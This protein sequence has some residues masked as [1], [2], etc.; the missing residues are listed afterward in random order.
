MIIL[1]KSRFWF[2]QGIVIMIVAGGL[3]AGQSPAGSRVASALRQTTPRL[4]L[5]DRY[6]LGECRHVLAHGDHVLFGSS[7]GLTIL[8]VHDPATPQVTGSVSLANEVRDMAV[9]GN[10]VYV[11]N[12]NTGL[13]IID[14]TDPAKPQIIGKHQTPGGTVGYPEEDD[15]AALSVSLFGQYAVV[16]LTNNGLEVIDVSSPAHPLPAGR[17][18]SYEDVYKIRVFGNLAFAASNKEPG[19]KV[20]DLSDP[21]RPRLVSETNVEFGVVSICRATDRLYVFSG[22]QLSIYNLKA[23]DHPKWI[24]SIPLTTNS[25]VHD[26][27]ISGGFA[28]AVG[29]IGL[30]VLDLQEP[31]NPKETLSRDIGLCMAVSMDARFLYLGNWNGLQVVDISN[32]PAIQVRGAYFGRR[33]FAGM[34]AEGDRLYL[35]TALHNEIRLLTLDISDPKSPRELSEVELGAAGSTTPGHIE[36][37]AGRL[38]MLM[39]REIAVFDLSDRDRPRF[40][41]TWQCRD[42]LTDLCFDDEI[43]LVTTA[44]QSLEILDIAQPDEIRAVGSFQLPGWG[45]AIGVIRDWAYLLIKDNGLIVLNIKAPAQPQVLATVPIKNNSAGALALIQES[46]SLLYVAGAD[47]LRV[48]DIDDPAKPKILGSYSSEYFYDSKGISVTGKNACVAATRGAFLFDVGDPQ[49]PSLKARFPLPGSA[50][51]VA[52][53]RNVIYVTNQSDLC[54]LTLN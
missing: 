23:E 48:I 29:S 31:D 28:Y 46:G 37:H 36:L 8:D 21:S 18:S 3:A 16:G 40:L 12:G 50:L 19:L 26:G 22:R 44:R 7:S 2:R 6:G 14:I 35:P 54:I 24:R 9:A 4:P 33:F 43:L 1:R 20:F 53:H 30:R 47:S 38:Y 5:L 34:A 32:L 27:V 17:Y 45:F 41:F 13:V 25:L 11:A 51:G 42:F 15:G 39:S 10:L 52:C 49:H